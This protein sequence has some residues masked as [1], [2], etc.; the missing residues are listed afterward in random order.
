LYLKSIPVAHFELG[1]FNF[2]DDLVKQHDIACDW[3]VVGGVHPIKTKELLTAVKSRV[4]RLTVQDP[5]LASKVEIIEDPEHLKKLRVEGAVGAVYQPN[6][7]RCWPYRLVTWI[8][9]GLVQAEAEKSDADKLFNLQ[10]YTSA[11]G[12][13]RLDDG[14]WIVHTSRGQITAKNVLLATNAYT[15]YLLPKMTELIVPVR[16]QVGA[17][18]TP[19]KGVQLQHSYAWLDNEGGDNYLIHRERDNDG[20]PLILGGERLIAKGNEVGVSRDDDIDLDIAYSLRRAMY[21]T[22]KLKEDGEKEDR[23][24]WAD[25]QWTGIMGYS[26]DDSPWVGPVPE[27]LGGGSGLWIS[28]GYTGHG[29]PVAARTG[30]AVAQMI[31]GT[32]EEKGAVNIPEEYEVSE[33]RIESMKSRV[34]MT[35]IEELDA[36]DPR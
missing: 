1:T 34:E 11:T 14:N 9:E 25:Y 6:A 26:K 32:Y 18:L 7:A 5:D 12:L 27:S 33:K 3:K 13:Q 21:G 36:L 24:L 22:L 30:V 23:E 29:M 31:A 8:L 20:G 2:L 16:G 35:L 17:L 15:S 4:K 19:E 28:A 10:T